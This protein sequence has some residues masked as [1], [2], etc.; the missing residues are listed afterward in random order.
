MNDLEQKLR[1]RGI[2][3]STIRRTLASLGGQLQPE[4]AQ[5]DIGRALEHPAPSRKRGS[6]N[7]GKG[8]VLVRVG[9][10]RVSAGELDDDGLVSCYK[11]FRDAIAD[12]L[13]F[14][15]GDKRIKFSY[16]QLVSQ[17][18]PGTIVRIERMI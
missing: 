5:P 18:R 6:R 1:N 15:D 11:H 9:I 13:G 3:E 16:G 17:G 4:T 2:G 10:I 8:L 7:L 12:S 14:D